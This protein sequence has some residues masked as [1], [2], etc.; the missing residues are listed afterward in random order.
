MDAQILSI[1]PQPPRAR[2]EQSE[3]DHRIANSLSIISSLVRASARQK[4]VVDPSRLLMEAAE[5]IDAVGRLHRDLAHAGS[6]Q[7]ALRPYLGKICDGFRRSLSASNTK[8]DIDCPSDIVWPAK[9]A[10]PLGLILVELL[11][12]SSKYAHP[13]GTPLRASI[14]CVA[15]ANG[16]RVRYEDDGVGFR[17]GFDPQ[18]PEHLG[19]RCVRALSQKLDATPSWES[20]GLGLRF[21]IVIPAFSDAAGA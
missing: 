14:A 6:D 12:N 4:R 5:R 2:L 15:E 3:A 16:H 18:N 13:A 19:L 21:E 20:D 11:T 9:R 10:M 8:I 7:V 1:S 17:E